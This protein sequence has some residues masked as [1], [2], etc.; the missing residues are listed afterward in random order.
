MNTYM[1]G[2]AKAISLREQDAELARKSS[3]ALMHFVGLN[4]EPLRLRLEDQQTGAE[5]EATVPRVVVQL[6]AE[7]LAQMAGGKSV[8]LILQEAEISTQQAAELL[9]V[10]R[11]YFVKLLEQGEIPYHKVGEQ[12][13]VCYSDLLA[14]SQIYQRKATVALDEMTAQAQKMNLYE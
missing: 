2:A 10:S 14:Y 5:V 7:A 9:G 3:D 6:I 4:E 11:P 1:T 12:R 8:S 13:R